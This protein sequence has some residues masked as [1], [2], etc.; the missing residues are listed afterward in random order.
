MRPVFRKLQFLFAMIVALIC[1][2][3]LF[4]S[5]HSFILY[6]G[7]QSAHRPRKIV[8]YAATAALKYMRL[9]DTSD[10]VINVA[11]IDFCCY[12]C[13]C[14][15]FLAVGCLLV[16]AASARKTTTTTTATIK[17]HEFLFFAVFFSK[18]EFFF[19]LIVLFV[20]LSRIFVFGNIRIN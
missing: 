12:C 10:G 3:F 6:P 18:S 17:K 5:C 15:C 16:S 14:C 13:C 20:Y 4:D 11:S 7:E 19:S 9:F 1:H 2:V 8:Y